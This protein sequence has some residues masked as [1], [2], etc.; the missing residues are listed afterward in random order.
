MF[1]LDNRSIEMEFLP[2]NGEGAYLWPF[3]LVIGMVRISLMM[4]ALASS[5]IYIWWFDVLMHSYETQHEI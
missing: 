1:V 2:T 5:S 3:S 4:F